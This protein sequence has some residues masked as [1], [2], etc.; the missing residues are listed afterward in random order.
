MHTKVPAAIGLAFALLIPLASHAQD[1]TNT[2]AAMVERSELVQK[3]QDGEIDWGKQMMYASAEAPMQPEDKVPNRARAFLAARDFAKMDAIASLLAVVEGTTVTYQ[4]SGKELMDQDTGLRR[5]IEGYVKNVEIISSERVQTDGGDAVRVTVGT[6]IY[7]E[8]TPGSAFMDK[9]AGTEKPKQPPLM[10]LPDVISVTVNVTLSAAAREHGMPASSR[11][12][13]AGVQFVAPPSE[14]PYT[15]LIIDARGFGV[16]QAI[17]PK[18][19]RL[20]GDHVYGILGSKSDPA[21]RQGTL[22]YARSLEGARE[23]DRCGDNPL[24]VRA[25]GRGG[26]RSMCDVVVSDKVA[27]QII[28]EDGITGFLEARRVIFVVDPPGVLAR[29]LG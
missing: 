19:R 15:S 4:G 21:I 3:V 18:V 13:D 5:T 7:G 29:S 25:V 6:R 10:E 28:A 14:G 24:I 22:S 2:P 9:L 27:S 11:P 23:C 1:V 16:P 17:S 8:S 12:V 20:N 26:G